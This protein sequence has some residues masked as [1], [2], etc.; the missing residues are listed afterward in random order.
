M[1]KAQDFRD[2]QG[3][4]IFLTV[5][6]KVDDVPE[7]ITGAAIWITFKN[8][9][10]DTDAEAVLQVAWGSASG[11]RGVLTSPASGIHEI[12]LTNVDTAN[13]NG[14][15]YYDIQYKSP[16][17]VVTTLLIGKWDFTDERT[18]TKS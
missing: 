7:D 14:E 5:A 8:N 12:H 10:A 4:D 6:V 18:V 16:S 17:G 2:V 11:A 15:Y 9:I 1:S 3:D 13:L